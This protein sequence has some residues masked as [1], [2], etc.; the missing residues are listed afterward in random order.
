MAK[1][2]TIHFIPLT[3]LAFKPE[4]M[5]PGAAGYDLRSPREYIIPPLTRQRIPLDLMIQIEG[6]YHGQIML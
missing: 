5:T 3:E 4:K 1:T 6:G 2:I